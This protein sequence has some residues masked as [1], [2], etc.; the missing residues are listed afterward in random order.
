MKT[1]PLPLSLLTTLLLTGCTGDVT[2]PPSAPA[3]GAPQP[4]PVQASECRPVGALHFSESLGT[5][6]GA[7]PAAWAA[8]HV[9]G[10]V[11]VIAGRRLSAQATSAL[12]GVTT[13]A[14]AD[15]LLPLYREPSRHAAQKALAG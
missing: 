10:E 3:P 1:A 14:V 2:P 5:D 12:S 15:G 9:P 8:P 13:W 4:P 6:K 11:L 7:D